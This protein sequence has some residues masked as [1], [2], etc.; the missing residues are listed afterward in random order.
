MSPSV[1]PARP[2]TS[3]LRACVHMQADLLE[4]AFLAWG[5]GTHDAALDYAA[6]EAAAA[7]PLPPA[8]D[9][10]LQGWYLDRGGGLL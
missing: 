7:C 1:L 3:S 9:R 6:F 5:V 2:P 10:A 8:L 4:E